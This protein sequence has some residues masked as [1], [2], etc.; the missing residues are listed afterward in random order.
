MNAADLPQ[1]VQLIGQDEI[2]AAGDRAR[3]CHG[4][5]KLGD[6]KPEKKGGYCHVFRRMQGTWH[7]VVCNRYEEGK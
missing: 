2:Q 3:W 5:S 6:F 4:C 1:C 7:P